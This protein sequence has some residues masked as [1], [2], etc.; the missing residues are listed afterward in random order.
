M[1]LTATQG[2]KGVGSMGPRFLPG[3]PSPL[4]PKLWHRRKG[5]LGEPLGKELCS[6]RKGPSAGS[7][8]GCPLRH[9]AEAVRLIQLL[10]AFALQ[11][12]PLKTDQQARPRPDKRAGQTDAVWKG[13]AK[14]PWPSPPHQ[15][16]LPCPASA[17]PS[18]AFAP[19][20]PPPMPPM[21]QPPNFSHPA[22]ASPNPASRNQHP[23]N[24]PPSACHPPSST[25]CC[26]RP[27][28]FPTSLPCH[29]QPAFPPPAQSV[30]PTCHLTL[31]SLPCPTQHPT[32]QPTLSHPVA[33][34][35]LAA[36]LINS[37]SYFRGHLC[38]GC[39]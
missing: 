25:C 2:T 8:A 36:P 1:L 5:C 18:L 6:G 13:Q 27:T 21:S 29:P 28:P 30:F 23:L 20:S 32:P 9:G 14:C 39:C 10:I 12:Q 3:Q 24:F 33:Q 26:H 4:T 31:S 7:H 16:S 22:P 35:S 17:N 34:L 11:Q 19:P 38:A 15:P 37:G